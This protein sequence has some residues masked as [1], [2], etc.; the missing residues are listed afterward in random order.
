MKR[1][2]GN[3]VHFNATL[4]RRIQTEKLNRL[5]V[6]ESVIALDTVLQVL[7]NEAVNRIKQ[8]L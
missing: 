8:G 5:L 3:I 6:T 7:G 2:S 1:H 4:A